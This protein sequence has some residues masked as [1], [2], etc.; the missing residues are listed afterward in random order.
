MK[1]LISGVIL[2]FFVTTSFAESVQTTAEFRNYMKKTHKVIVPKTLVAGTK[3]ANICYAIDEQSCNKL[4]DMCAKT[5]YRSKGC[6]AFKQR[7]EYLFNDEY[8]DSFI[9]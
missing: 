9:K 2:L 7:L 3:A 8:K 1:N 5:K 4:D 6:R